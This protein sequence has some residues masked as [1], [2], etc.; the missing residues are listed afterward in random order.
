MVTTPDLPSYK[1]I[2][3]SA[4]ASSVPASGSS[5]VTITLDDAYIIVGMPNVSTGT[6]DAEV[7]VVNGGRNSFVVRATNN[8]SAAQDIAISYSVGVIRKV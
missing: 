1:I 5:D 4:T 2:T 3:G 7:I 6:P 8:S